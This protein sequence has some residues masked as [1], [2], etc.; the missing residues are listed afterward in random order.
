MRDVI[1]ILQSDWPAKMCVHGSKMVR[2]VRTDPKLYRCMVS[3]TLPLC[4]ILKE[5]NAKEGAVWH[6]DYI[7]YDLY[8]HIYVCE[9]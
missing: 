8:N 4:V 3:Q 2:S 6:Q 7:I 9:I 1:C 5:L